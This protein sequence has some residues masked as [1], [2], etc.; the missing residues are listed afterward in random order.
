VVIV[1]VLLVII[2]IIT[3]MRTEGRAPHVLLV[4]AA[5]VV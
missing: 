2:I 1:V 5:L 4:V 3:N